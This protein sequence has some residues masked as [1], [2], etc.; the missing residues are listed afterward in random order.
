MSRCQVCTE[1]PKAA[2]LLLPSLESGPH[3][4]NG[5][6]GGT[7][8]WQV[9]TPATS[10]YSLALPELPLWWKVSSRA[11]APA[12]RC[13]LP[14]AWS[15]CLLVCNH[16]E[17]CFITR[18][19]PSAGE[20]GTGK[21][22]T[23]GVPLMHLEHTWGQQPT[24]GGYRCLWCPGTKC[25][26][27]GCPD[28]SPTLKPGTVR[29]EQL[30]FPLKEKQTWAKNTGS[31]SLGVLVKRCGEWERRCEKNYPVLGSSPNLVNADTWNT[32]CFP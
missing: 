9:I 3:S 27:R 12:R 8:Q 6:R 17:G 2:P 11:G 26:G 32:Y 30:W 25:H 16:P 18:P 5:A 14:G 29:E 21:T 1:S 15:S 4:A 22:G 19:S 10:L 20:S 23:G 24:D 7:E 13:P 28:Q 31:G